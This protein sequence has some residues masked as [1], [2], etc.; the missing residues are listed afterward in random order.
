MKNGVE[1]LKLENI[2]V[3][4]KGKLNSLLRILITGV[5]LIVSLVIGW[6]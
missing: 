2:K 1:E 3:R 6:K 5:I 4:A